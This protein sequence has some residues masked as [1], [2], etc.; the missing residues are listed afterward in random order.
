MSK[1]VVLISGVPGSGGDIIAGSLLECKK[2]KLWLHIN[3]SIDDS[4]EKTYVSFIDACEHNLAIA[5]TGPFL[6][7]EDINPFIEIATALGYDIQQ[8]LT[9]HTVES[10]DFAPGEIKKMQLQLNERIID[11][12]IE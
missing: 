10:T 6:T 1:L 9:K 4:Y 11:W 2:V 7:K 3:P 8:I 12:G 5:V